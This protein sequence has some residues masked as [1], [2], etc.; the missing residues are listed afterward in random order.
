MNQVNCKNL[1]PNW[2]EIKW[3]FEPDGSLR[4]IYVEK[5][6]IEDWKILIEFLNDNYS[7]KFGPT[8]E[9]NFENKINS[10]YVT[11]LLNGES[12]EM[13]CRTASILIDQII[14]NTHFFYSEQI[15]FDV[16][17]REI[18]N[19]LDYDKIINFMFEISKNLNKQVIL[20]GENQIE[21]PLI[22]VDFTTNSV[23]ALTKKEVE[24]LRE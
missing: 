10:A 13:E 24:K 23:E 9:N 19:S 16:D 11:E 6:T 12:K 20:A 8:A 5:V 17:P 4:D 3:I 21:L 1:T 7:I 22:K 2:I 15:E 18:N 14:I